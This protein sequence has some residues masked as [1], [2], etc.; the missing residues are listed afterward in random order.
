MSDSTREHEEAIRSCE[1]R[2]EQDRLSLLEELKAKE[3]SLVEQL[4]TEKFGL[5]A[6]IDSVRQELEEER[7]RWS[8]RPSLPADLERIKSL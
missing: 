2:F 7:E 8:T 1:V 6:E 4:E 5:R 3:D